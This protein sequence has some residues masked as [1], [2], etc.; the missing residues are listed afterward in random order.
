VLLLA[1]VVVAAACGDEA[2]PPATDLPAGASDQVLTLDGRERGYRVYVP[3]SVVDRRIADVPLLVVLDDG[4]RGYDELAE[5]HGAVVAYS[6]TRPGD[7]AAVAAA[8]I[9]EVVQRAP[10]GP[11][12]VTGQGDGGTLAFAV[13][14]ER[15]GDV[16]AVAVVGGRLEVEACEPSRA[17]PLLLVHRDEDAVD[18]S[19]RAWTAAIGCGR[20]EQEAVEPEGVVTEWTDC[21]GAVPTRQVVGGGD[22]TELVGA[23][24]LG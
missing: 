16:D 21:D 18:R 12:Y 23:F 24:L 13:A 20:P 9:R 11:V 10:I 2:A 15:A 8:V 1:L 17:L 14:C 22:A 6:E 4:G 5:E 19:M 3:P 7:T